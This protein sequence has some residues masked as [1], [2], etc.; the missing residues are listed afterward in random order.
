[1]YKALV[2]Q[3]PYLFLSFSQS[4]KGFTKTLNALR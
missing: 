1:M 2:L 4:H 3:E